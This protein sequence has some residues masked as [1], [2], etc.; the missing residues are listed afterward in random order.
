M[1]RQGRFAPARKP[2]RDVR[3][4][5]PCWSQVRAAMRGPFVSKPPDG[6]DDL[7]RHPSSTARAGGMGTSHARPA[8]G[9]PPIGCYDCKHSHCRAENHGRRASVVGHFESVIPAEGDLCVNGRH[10]TPKPRSTLTLTLSLQGR[11]NRTRCPVHAGGILQRSPEAGIHLR[12]ATDE[13]RGPAGAG[14]PCGAQMSNLLTTRASTW[15]SLP[16]HGRASHTPNRS[17]ALRSA[18]RRSRYAWHLRLCE[19]WWISAE[20]RLRR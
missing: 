11:G 3:R 5:F 1:K 16:A 10:P 15:E 19:A 14:S 17:G 13:S 7:P 6:S 20:P 2:L 18:R 4:N 12:K 8:S 9:S